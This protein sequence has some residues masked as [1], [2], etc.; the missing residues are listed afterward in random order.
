MKQI[1]RLSLLLLTLLL[2]TVATAHDIEVDGIYYKI[3]DNRA[4]VTYRGNHYWDYSNYYSGSV[5]IPAAFTYYGTTYT[6]TS[7]GG[8]AFSAC[9]YLTGVIIPNSVTS[10]SDRAFSYCSGLTSVTIPDSVSSIGD[11]AFLNCSGLTSINIPNSVTSIGQSA[12]YGCYGLTSI[13]VAGSNPKY[14][15][16]GNCNAIIESATNTLILGSYNT[17]IPNSVTSI[18]DYAFFNCTNLTSITIP[19][20]VIFIGEHVF[21][22]Y[23]SLTFVK[24]IGTVPPVMA[25][26]N[27]FSAA[28]YN[29]AT[30]LVPPQ[31]VDTYQAA[32]YWHKFAHIEGWGSVGRGDIDSDGEVSIR[33][34]TSLID[35]LLSGNAS[36]VN[37]EGA[38]C[39]RDGSVNI[40]DVTDLIDYL[41]SGTWN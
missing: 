26:E 18:G 6:V 40:S 12:F 36:G 37:L 24:C 3:H 19:N 1:I 41:L 11:C 22:D 4:T 38:D 27:C 17:V 13:T 39:D 28:T 14:D 34:V 7:I 33:D 23:S 21:S 15:S 20:S 5:V 32:D 8:Y 25:S 30:L 9:S 10:I 31:F 2:P 35:Y 16:R 29:R